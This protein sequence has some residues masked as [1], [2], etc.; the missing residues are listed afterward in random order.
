VGLMLRSAL[1][2]PKST[3]TC[4]CGHPAGAASEDCV[5]LAS[6]ATGVFRAAERYAAALFELGRRAARPRRGGLRLA[7]SCGRCW[8]QAGPRA[9][10]R[11]PILTRGEQGKAIAALVERAGFT[12]LVR[13][14]S[15]S[16]RR[17]AGLCR[18][19][20]IEAI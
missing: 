6:E 18:S 14:S 17:T 3:G 16:S 8:R 19:A 15:L 11:S 4:C 5:S 2:E 10:V 20:M 13:D 1:R 9:L 12:P 7:G